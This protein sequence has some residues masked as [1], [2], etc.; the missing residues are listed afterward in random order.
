MATTNTNVVTI[1]GNLTRDPED[2]A[3]GKGAKFSIAVNEAY[4]PKDSDEWT[5]Y[6]SYFDCTTWGPASKPV[7]KFLSKGSK[8]IVSGRLKQERWEKDGDKRSR[9]V[10]HTSQVEFMPKSAG[11]SSGSSGGSDGFDDDTDDDIPF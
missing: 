3:D 10:I 7:L 8:V 6:T 2:I 5:T 1:A 9:V 4:K 11:T